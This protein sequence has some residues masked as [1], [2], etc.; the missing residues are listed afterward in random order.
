MPATAWRRTKQ[1]AE[2]VGDPA[3]AEQH[4]I[5]PMPVDRAGRTKEYQDGGGFCSRGRL[6][7]ADRPPPKLAQY[8]ADVLEEM[9]NRGVALHIR[10][11]CATG[12][13]LRLPKEDTLV[14]L[15]LSQANWWITSAAGG[16]TA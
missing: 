9:E 12:E 16:P 10:K 2:S 5:R 1:W 13:I 4:N 15:A 6:H 3:A 8:G 11:L 14:A 7:P